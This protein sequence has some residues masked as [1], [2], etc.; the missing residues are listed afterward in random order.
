M[1][2][3]N[4]NQLFQ[5]LGEIRGEQR[6]TNGSLDRIVTWMKD[7]DKEDKDRHSSTLVEIGKLKDKN[8]EARGASLATKAIITSAI[9][10]LPIAG[11]AITY[12]VQAH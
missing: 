6:A 8:A 4:D 3:E 11:A 2:G 7:H 1:S 12:L 10:L 9:A 5:M